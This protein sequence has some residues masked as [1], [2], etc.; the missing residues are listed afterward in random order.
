MTSLYANILVIF[1]LVLPLTTVRSQGDQRHAEILSQLDSW[2]VVQLEPWQA[3]A[4]R[5]V[6]NDHGVQ[7]CYDRRNEFQLSDSAK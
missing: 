6:W 4:I 7:S 5:Q 2:Q 1:G 3:D